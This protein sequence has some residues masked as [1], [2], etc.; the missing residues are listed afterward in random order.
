MPAMK[1]T[2][3]GTRGSIAAPGAG[4]VRYGGNTSCVQLV[5]DAG[6]L[7]VLDCGTGARNL[8][9]H[10]VKLLPDGME[11][12]ILFTHTH[13][14]HIQGFP[15]FAPIF[16]PSNTWKIYGPT[17]GEHEL[18]QALSG[19]MQYT[20]FPV[21]LDQINAS[22]TCFDLGEGD[23]DIEDVHVC[24]QYLNHPA[25]TLGYRIEVGGATV[26]YCTDHE[27]F[28]PVLFGGDPPVPSLETII[29]AG[30]RRH[31]D[32]LA[33][34]DLVIHDA[35]YTVQEYEYKRNWGH[36]TIDYVV[37]VA[38][39][40]GVKR[41]A[42]YHHDP[43]HD[44][45]ALDRIQADARSRA[46]RL[47]GTM[48][49]F[50]A[51]EGETIDLPENLSLDGHDSRGAAT[52]GPRVLVADD[53]AMIRELVRD[54]LQQERVVVE[55]VS[56]GEALLSRVGE[57]RPD[58]I[59][60]DMRLPHIDGFEVLERLR[61]SDGGRDLP[62]IMLTAVADAESIERGFQLG[63]TDYMTKPFTPAQL[64]ARVSGWLRRA[65]QEPPARS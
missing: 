3:W 19:Q 49:V 18:E 57:S 24:S 31:A 21:E 26:V 25:V 37:D 52:R 51:R 22:I 29:H 55:P 15:F 50:C 7:L 1:I 43:L 11:G 2:F 30:D 4:T 39:V 34:A 6:T 58:L 17:D 36:S 45:E 28:V 56:T 44:D 61:G 16:A 60:L 38:H 23:L 53:E 42:L 13:W 40:A 65:A 63:A 20:Y 59:L 62:V 32:F 10:L 14:D 54:I 47:G 12:H 48:D 46:A 35:Q 41:L 5:T 8:G 9:N 27:P 64:R 33:G